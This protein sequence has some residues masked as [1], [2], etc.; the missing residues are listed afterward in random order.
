MPDK[1]QLLVNETKDRML[2]F[3]Q[4]LITI[5]SPPGE[6]TAVRNCVKDMIELIGFDDI[7]IDA[8][9]NICGRL[10]E[11]KHSIAFDCHMD[12]VDVG[13]PDQW[14]H[15]PFSGLIDNGIMYG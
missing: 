8:M 10:G 11:G 12:T 2:K 13:N 14:K 4:K 6:E 5:P 7:F 15:D 9:G 1:I 3:T